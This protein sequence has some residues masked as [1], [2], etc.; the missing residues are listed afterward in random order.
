MHHDY[1][2]ALAQAGRFDEAAA[3][4]RETLRLQ[5]DNASAKANLAR[6]KPPS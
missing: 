6:L 1:G 2:V 4:F 3:Q 5:P